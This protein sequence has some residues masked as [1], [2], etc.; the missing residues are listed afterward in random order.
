MNDWVE[1]KKNSED[2]VGPCPCLRISHADSIC[3]NGQEVRDVNYIDIGDAEATRSF[4]GNEGLC[5]SLLY[6]NPRNELCC[7]STGEPIVIRGRKIDLQIFKQALRRV[8]I[9]GLEQ[10][11]SDRADVCN[12][13]I[14]K[15]ISNR[16]EEEIEQQQPKE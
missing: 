11:T 1:E 6:L 8:A 10:A 4:A 9:W 3:I 2:I 5:L 14:Y 15:V 16:F 13:C 12:D 7:V